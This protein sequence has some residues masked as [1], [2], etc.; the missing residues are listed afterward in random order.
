[1]EHGGE[2]DAGAKM[3]GVSGDSQ[4]RLGGGLEEDGVNYGLVLV[5]DVSDRS[6]QGKA[7]ENR[8]SATQRRESGSRATRS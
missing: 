5:G 6:R 3:L 1:M 2:T 8:A 4:E 7:L